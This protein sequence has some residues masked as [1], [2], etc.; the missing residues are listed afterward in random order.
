M[1]CRGATRL[2]GARGKKQ[3][4]GLAPRSN[5]R[6]FGSKCTVL[7][8]VFMTLLWVFGLPEWFGVR[9]IIP[10]CTPSLRLWCYA[11]TTG[12]FSVNKKIFKSERHELHLHEHLQF[13]NAIR[14]RSYMNI[15]NFRTQYG[16]DLAQT[17]DKGN[18]WHFR[19]LRE[20]FVSRICLP[21]A[22]FR[23]GPVFVLLIIKLF[24]HSTS[25]F[26]NVR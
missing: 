24:R 19:L 16:S 11:I 9:G 21:H 8:K 12:K 18:W 15:C 13:S 25:Y 5:L 7:K 14:L 2:D 20:V 10:P 4:S 23:R 26:L 3:V 17:A 22:F 6:S 1:T